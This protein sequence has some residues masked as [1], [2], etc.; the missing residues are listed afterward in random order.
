M[1]VTMVMVMVM[2]MM[3]LMIMMIMTQPTSLTAQE[4]SWGTEACLRARRTHHIVSVF[5]SSSNFH[6]K[7][8][9]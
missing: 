5:N 4:Y 6:F 3:T 2:I 7:R 8:L 9:I 1:M